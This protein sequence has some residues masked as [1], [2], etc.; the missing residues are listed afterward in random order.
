MIN[1][2][3]L[4]CTKCAA[5]FKAPDTT[6]IGVEIG[7]CRRFP[8]VPVLV[9]VGPGQANLTAMF[10]PVGVDNPICCSYVVREEKTKIELT[11]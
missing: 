8:P 6:M 9:P 11:N 10:P 2:Q 4:N 1:K 5:Y 7:Q 3:E